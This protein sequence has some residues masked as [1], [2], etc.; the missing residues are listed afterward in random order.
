[1]CKNNILHVVSKLTCRIY[2]KVKSTW[3][4]IYNYIIDIN[5]EED[6]CATKYKIF[7]VVYNLI[8]NTS[9][10]RESKYK[11]I[12]A[13]MFEWKHMSE[14]WVYILRR[15]VFRGSTLANVCLVVLSA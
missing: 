8:T 14:N 6:K 11:N 13:R 12:R 2:S 1:M 15:A 9:L 4:I 3:V 10:Q 7:I 5:N